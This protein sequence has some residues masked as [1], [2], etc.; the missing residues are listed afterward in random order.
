M[1]R[2]FDSRVTRLA[3][4]APAT[5]R[6]NTFAFEGAADFARRRRLLIQSHQPDIVSNGT[7]LSIKK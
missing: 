1:R 2:H 4:L 7:G 3:N 5:S 6:Y